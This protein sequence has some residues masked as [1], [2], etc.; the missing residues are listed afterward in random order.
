MG[1]SI[2][3]HARTLAR[4]HTR[5]L[6]RSHPPTHV[7]AL[8]A[9]ALA[10]CAY[11]PAP[12][13]QAPVSAQPHLVA[14]DVAECHAVVKDDASA[15]SLQQAARRSLDYLSN[16][17]PDRTFPLLDRQVTAGE[18]A[19]MMR[20]VG[21]GAQVCD[22]FRLY[23]AELPRGLL[24]TGYYQPE[25][26]ARRTR[27]ARFRY[28]LYRIPDNLV[29]V[30][31]T[32]FCPACGG[33]VIQGRVKDGQ[34]V[35]YYSR[36]EIDAG[37]LAD[38]G[39]EVAWLD[40]PVEAFFLHVQGSALLHFDDGVQMQISYA[41]SNGRPY[42]SLG[43]VLV[44]QGKMERAAVSLQSLKDYLRAHPAE[45]EQLM[46]SNQ[47]Y[48]FFRPVITGPIGSIG[49]P[50][51]AGRSIAADASI[52]PRGGLVFLR[53]LPGDVPQGAPAAP[54]LSR[55]VLIQDA[56]TAITGPGRIDVFFGSGATAAS[57]AGTL[58]NPGELYMV[59]PQ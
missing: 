20:D 29:D 58:R 56:G 36:A 9:L 30:D 23:R 4:S 59:L 51:T 19:T 6:A 33:R 15:T 18:L 17:P 2:V 47:R 57:I 43:R 27:S 48:I 40:D 26:P 39:Y 45:Q 54:I 1:S 52:Y 44:E 53:I 5:T 41:G 21:D 31:L 24:V 3:R 42:T 55:V 46:E 8:F 35:P 11:L 49:V 50:L 12:A 34:L 7:A 32:Q 16:L 14:L 37:A 25:L 22:R 28:P 38:R 13:G 10:S